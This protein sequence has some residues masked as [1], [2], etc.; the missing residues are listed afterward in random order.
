MGV[1]SLFDGTVGRSFE[2]RDALTGVIGVD[3]A[4]S[5]AW[6]CSPAYDRLSPVVADVVEGRVRPVQAFALS[7][8]R[9]T[10]N[11]YVRS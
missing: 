8:D 2:V 3:G 10:R 1:R 7:V 11:A 5:A 4:F 9:V 6:R